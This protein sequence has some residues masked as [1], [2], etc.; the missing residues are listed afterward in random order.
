[1]DYRA[2]LFILNNKNTSFI[3]PKNHPGLYKH[4]NNE[5]HFISSNAP[6]RLPSNKPKSENY[7]LKINNKL[8]QNEIVKAKACNKNQGNN[9]KETNLC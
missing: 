4:R 6:K 3:M 5:S 9:T 7:N 8:F 2:C 1:M